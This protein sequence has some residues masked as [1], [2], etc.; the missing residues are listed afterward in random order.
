MAVKSGH[1]GLLDA[2]AAGGKLKSV[3]AV[4]SGYEELPHVMATGGKFKMF[5]LLCIMVYGAGVVVSGPGLQDIK[6]IT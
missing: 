4:M 3:M 6:I 1:E 2:M 5:K